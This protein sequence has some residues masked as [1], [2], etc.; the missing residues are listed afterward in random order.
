M[1]TTL[2][3]IAAIVIGYI[4]WVGLIEILDGGFR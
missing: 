3:A 2:A 1:R 4:L